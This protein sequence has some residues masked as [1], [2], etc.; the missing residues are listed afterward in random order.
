MWSGCTNRCCTPSINWNK[1]CACLRPL[2]PAGHVPPARAPRGRVVEIGYRQSQ[3]DEEL[4]AQ[5]LLALPVESWWEDWMRHAG[6]LLDDPELVNI[7][8]QSPAEAMAQEPHSRTAFHSRRSGAPFDGAQ[9]RTQLELWRAGAGGARQPGLSPV[10]AYWA[11]PDAA[12]QD[13]R[14]AWV[15][16]GPHR[17]A[18]IAPARRRS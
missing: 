5:A 18:A 12:R 13:H 4:F 10:H 11:S 16:A 7:V 2:P 8:H 17:R 1:P 9:T 15:A 6:R 3:Q 14:Q